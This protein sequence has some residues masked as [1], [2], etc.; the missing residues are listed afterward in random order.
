M[1]R[2]PPWRRSE[3]VTPSTAGINSLLCNAEWIFSH[4]HLYKTAHMLRQE[5]GL[6][7]AQRSQYMYEAGEVTVGVSYTPCTPVMQS[8]TLLLRIQPYS[9]N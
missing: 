4:L 2:A 7:G 3:T 5:N 9:T 1:V 6:L 8:R